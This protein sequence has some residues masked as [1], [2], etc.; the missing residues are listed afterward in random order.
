MWSAV[1]QPHGSSSFQNS[2]EGA[3]PLWVSHSAGR[4]K[5]ARALLEMKT[6]ARPWHTSGPQVMAKESHMTKPSING[7]EMYTPLKEGTKSPREMAGVVYFS[8][9]KEQ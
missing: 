8:C 2:S 5:K 6:S 1:G 7:A 4:V 9:R 3:V